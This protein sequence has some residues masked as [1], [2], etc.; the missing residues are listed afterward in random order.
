MPN[1]YSAELNLGIAYGGLGRDE[2]AGKQFERALALA[3]NLAEPHF[4]YGRWLKSKGRLGEAQLQ[5]EAAIRANRLYF[6]A[7]TLLIE[8]YTEQ[9]SFPT[10]DR[11]IEDTLRLSNNDDLAR[12]YMQERSTPEGLLNLSAKYCNA[13]NYEDCLAAAKRAIELRP[14]YA[15][16][17]NNIAAAYIA[18]QKWDEGIQAAREALRI[19][20]DY[21]AAKSNLEWALGHRK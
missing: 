5:L 18:M 21:D 6:P 12:R 20:P 1:Y 2:E 14:A 9:K 3:P 10:R 7:R 11:L 19:K 4:Y 15:E 16:A 13:G 8:V 17:Y